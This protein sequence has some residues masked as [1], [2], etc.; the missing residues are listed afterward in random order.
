MLLVKI[1]INSK[2]IISKMTESENCKEIFSDIKNLWSDWAKDST[3][4]GLSNIIKS[5]N[6]VLKTVWLGCYLASCS[7]CIYLISLSVISYAS[8]PVSTV[9]SIV[10]DVPATFPT[11]TFCHLS[12]L[13]TDNATINEQIAD[14]L[15]SQNISIS[16]LS[17]SS[18][19]TAATRVIASFFSNL[20][21]S[22]KLTFGNTIKNS[23]YSCNFNSQPCPSDWH[24][25]Y[26]SYYLGNCYKFNSNGTYKVERPGVLPSLQLQ[27]VI[28]DSSSNI[29]NY[30]DSGLRV[31]IENSSKTL[32]LVYENGISLSPGFLYDIKV[33]RTYYSRLDVP[34][35]NCVK[36]LTRNTKNPTRVMQIMFNQLNFSQYSQL[37]CQ[38]FIF[39]E[40]LVQ[41]CSCVNP[42]SVYTDPY[43]PRCLDSNQA[44]CQQ[45]AFNT[46]YS[47]PLFYF[48]SQ[49][50]KGKYIFRDISFLIGSK[51]YIYL[52]MRLFRV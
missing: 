37:N 30:L 41:N 16:T 32:P 21:M 49:C 43:F 8:N 12:P 24:E 25:W 23:V 4:H 5:K 35:S 29:S 39:Q 18:Y 19:Q 15:A 36:D 38:N 7:I 14:L 6:P 42:N 3:S 51:Y 44:Q 11:V 31:L 9:V 26:L 10:D 46:V 48:D 13:I 50:P 52:R 33:S 17:L 45:L 27:F 1:K 2:N 28:G 22:Q 34:Y 40:Y 47:N 20:S